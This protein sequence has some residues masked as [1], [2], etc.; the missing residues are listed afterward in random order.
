MELNRDE[1]HL[2]RYRDYDRPDIK[3]AKFGHLLNDFWADDDTL[4]SIFVH[5]LSDFEVRLEGM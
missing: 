4:S 5:D 3:I 1:S 2:L